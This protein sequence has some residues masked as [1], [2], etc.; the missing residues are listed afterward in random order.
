MTACTCGI[1]GHDHSAH[2]AV[3]IEA[4][5]APKPPIPVANT[6]IWRD[7]L[8]LLGR[9]VNNDAA[10]LWCCPGGKADEPGP[11][12]RTAI[13]EVYE[14]TGMA[15]SP[16]DFTPLDLWDSY[17]AENGQ[18]FVC[19]FFEIEATHLRDPEVREPHKIDQWRWFDPVRLP[20]P[21]FNGDRRAITLS[22]FNRMPRKN[23]R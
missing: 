3:E 2:C 13:R 20:D 21:M 12:Y 23:H 15:F 1:G 22:Y 5:K 14:E 18:M 6:V 17:E 4:R 10:G 11:M 7:D 16:S 8:V 9:R 19:V